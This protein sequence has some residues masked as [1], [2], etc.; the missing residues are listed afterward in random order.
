MKKV[1]SDISFPELERDVL[2]YW[3]ENNIF[4]KSLDPSLNKKEGEEPRK[5]YVSMTVLRLLLDCHT[6]DIF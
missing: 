6:M 4:H 3:K 1:R 5:D 2:K